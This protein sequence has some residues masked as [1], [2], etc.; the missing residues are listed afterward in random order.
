MTQTYHFQFCGTIRGRNAHPGQVQSHHFHNQLTFL[1]QTL[2]IS[3]NVQRISKTYEF[4]EVRKTGIRS[5]IRETYTEAHLRTITLVE[6]Q[7]VLI[8]RHARL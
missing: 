6:L 5:A 4:S 7:I 3:S 1:T 2:S 8:A